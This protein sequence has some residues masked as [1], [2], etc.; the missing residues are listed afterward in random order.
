MLD[1]ILLRHGQSTWNAQNLFTG[2]VDVD[3]TEAGED[4]ARAGGEPLSQPKTSQTWTACSTIQSPDRA[5]LASQPSCPLIGP[6]E[7]I[8]VPEP[9]SS[10]PS[11]PRRIAAIA[12]R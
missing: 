11:S 4:E 6:F 5:R 12:S 3:L 2:W 8:Q 7:L 1:L 9:E 10:G